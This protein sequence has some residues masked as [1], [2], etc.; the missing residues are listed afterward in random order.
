MLVSHVHYYPYI[1][2]SRDVVGAWIDH[3]DDG[4]IVDRTII[5]SR[6]VVYMLSFCIQGGATK[7]TSANPLVAQVSSNIR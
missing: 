2:N 3:R 5:T 6:H 4:R 7:Y 1:G